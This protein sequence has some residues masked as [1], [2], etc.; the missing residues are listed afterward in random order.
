MLFRIKQKQTVKCWDLTREK[1]K[2]KEEEKKKELVRSSLRG[3]A[4]NNHN[5][6]HEH[7]KQTFDGKLDN[8]TSQ[9]S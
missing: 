8:V 6:F 3:N 9:E 1:K 5:F 7:K 2:R 4:T